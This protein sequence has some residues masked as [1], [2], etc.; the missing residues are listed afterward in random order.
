MAKN[1]IDIVGSELVIER[2]VTLGDVSPYSISFESPTVEL[3]LDR[4]KFYERGI[5]KISLGLTDINE[6]GGIAPTDI[7]DAN[8]KILNSIINLNGYAT[9]EWVI[10]NTPQGDYLQTITPTDTPTGT[11]VVYWTAME[12]GTYTNFGGVVVNPNS[13][14]F[15][16][17]N[18]IGEFSISQTALDLTNYVTQENLVASSLITSTNEFSTA[19]IIEDKLIANNFTISNEPGWDITKIAAEENQSYVIDNFTPPPLGCNIRFE[20]ISGALI[21]GTSITSVPSTITTP[22]GTYNI[23]MTIKQT[24]Q[25]V[26][27]YANLI[28]KKAENSRYD[29]IASNNLKEVLNDN[30]SQWSGKKVLFFGDSITNGALYGDWTNDVFN[31]LGVNIGENW[32]SSGATSK[33][34]YEILTGVGG[35]FGST[36]NLSNTNAIS[37]MIGHNESTIGSVSE[38]LSVPDPANYPDNMI[39]NLAKCLEYIWSQNNEISIYLC[40]VH[41]TDR[42]GYTLSPDLSASITELANYYAIPII[43][44]FKEVG[45]NKKNISTMLYDGTHL[46]S[47]GNKRMAKCISSG[48]TGK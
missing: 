36:P 27:N 17:R 9:E 43:D 15:I 38:I 35:W 45:I 21:S 48:L 46:F 44:V 8:D 25:L 22:S 6:I 24:S 39:G 31:S 29:Y 20:D 5:Y 34:I 33:R 42:V 32:G 3:V 2:I 30:K 19:E 1:N 41:Q 14:A 13:I 40:T 11:D 10:E 23:Y 4:I 7:V 37:I 12:A 28:F 18:L 47:I 16:S 26:S